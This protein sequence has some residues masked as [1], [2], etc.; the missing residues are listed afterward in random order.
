MS[1]DKYWNGHQWKQRVLERELEEIGRTDAT[2]ESAEESPRGVAVLD[3]GRIDRDDPCPAN[4]PA[5]QIPLGPRVEVRA[6]GTLAVVAVD[7]VKAPTD[8]LIE[9]VIQPHEK[10][11]DE[12]VITPE[13]RARLRRE[14]GMPEDK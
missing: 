13:V 5:D 14:L 1:S 11:G 7:D 9:G 4:A 2:R 12:V 8:A 3:H 6:D 10:H